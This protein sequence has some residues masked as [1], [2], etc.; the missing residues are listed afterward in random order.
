MLAREVRRVPASKHV[1]A[2]LSEMRS[3]GHHLAVVVDEYGGTAGIVTLED[4]IEEL[5][6]EIRDEYDAVPEPDR[7]PGDVDGRLHLADFAQQ[8]RLRAAAR[9]VRV[10]RRLP[11]G[12]ARPVAGHRGRGRRRTGGG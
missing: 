4:L 3:E 9:A 2:A 8:L 12:A 6:G 7:L 11:D 10:A 5:V 1:L